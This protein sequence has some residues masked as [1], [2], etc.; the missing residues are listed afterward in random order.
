MPLGGVMKDVQVS[1]SIHAIECKVDSFRYEIESVNHFVNIFK[2]QI[3]ELYSKPNVPQEFA[4][5]RRTTESFFKEVK[6]KFSTNKLLV[7]D[8]RSVLETLKG[9]VGFQD[10]T[11]SQIR[12]SIPVLQQQIT[13]TKDTLSQKIVS[14]NTA[15][16][17]RFD[18]HAV[19]QKS[20]LET[21]KEQAF[22]A[23]KSIV[24]SNTT[25]LD[26]LEIAR[27]D[28]SNAMLKVNNLDLSVKMLERKL[29]KL[30]MQIKKVEL[31]QKE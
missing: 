20:Q 1:A 25:L 10:L 29:E 9:V 17:N 23:P 27:M 4:E 13:D 7:D 6:D 14:I 22:S 8:I 11:I 3:D 21:L 24:E 2:T 15:F 5:F 18:D 30:E 12:E 26:K 16:S 31:T 19:K 28:G